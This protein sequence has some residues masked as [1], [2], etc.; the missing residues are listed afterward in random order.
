[1]FTLS[2]AQNQQQRFYIETLATVAS[3]FLADMQKSKH[4]PNQNLLSSP[5]ASAAAKLGSASANKLTI[6]AVSNNRNKSPTTITPVSSNNNPSAGQ[7][8]AFI[9]PS[10][11]S[12][13]TVLPLETV[14][15]RIT[16]E[17]SNKT[18]KLL[19]DLS[20][21]RRSRQRKIMVVNTGNPPRNMLPKLNLINGQQIIISSDLLS[22]NQNNNNSVNK[23]QS[24][25][26]LSPS[27][28]PNT[29]S[30]NLASMNSEPQQQQQQNIVYSRPVAVARQI[31]NNLPNANPAGN[32]AVPTF[33]QETS[34]QASSS[35][36]IIPSFHKAY[37]NLMPKLLNTLADNQTFSNVNNDIQISN[38]ENNNMNA[39]SPQ[40]L[41]DMSLLDLSMNTNDSL[42]F[43]SSA[44]LNAI[45]NENANLISNVGAGSDSSL[46]VNNG[47]HML[48]KTGQ[49]DTIALDSDIKEASLDLNGVFSSVVAND[50]DT[51]PGFK[52][53]SNDK[54]NEGF[55]QILNENSNSTLT[56]K[57]IFF[58]LVL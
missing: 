5:S 56:S 46:V 35:K 37:S 32:Y 12:A 17:Q 8:I 39:S 13:T 9:Q 53:S 42:L 30:N 48:P 24:V 47:H 11:P 54:V 28:T 58:F 40:N 2:S 36:T 23:P 20:T 51:M 25:T 49:S 22:L 41:N 38:S 33:V 7:Q 10:N 26:V 14:L 44:N 21:K 52:L 43:G 1:L 57:L 29:S 31:V 27:I 34:V 4:E 55:S 50:S 18:K 3:S 16:E 45:V 6:T 19:S 15:Q